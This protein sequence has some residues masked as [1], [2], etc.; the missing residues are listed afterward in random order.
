MKNEPAPPTKPRQRIFR[1]LVW[2]GRV[3]GW[4]LLLVAIL[5]VVQAEFLPRASFTFSILSSVSLGL[6]AGV[7]IIALEVFL[8]FFDQYLARN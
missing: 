4:T 6:V 7:W 2:G 8:R 1:V 5:G 3:V